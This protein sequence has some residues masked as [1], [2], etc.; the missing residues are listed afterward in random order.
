MT[1]KP[2]LADAGLP[3][4]QLDLIEQFEADYNAVDHFLRKAPGS[5]KLASF[6]H[7]VN[8]YS[9]THA[10]WRDADLLRMIAEL[11][12]VIVHGK[13]APYAYVAVPTPTVV[14]NLRG[15]RDRLINPARVIPKFRGE[16]ETVS[17]DDTLARVL[18]IIKHREYSQFPVYEGKRFQG[19]LTENGITRWLAN[20]VATQF[21]LVELDDVPVKQVLQNEEERR[22]YQFVARDM[23]VD[24][25]S[26]LFK[27]HELLEAVLITA[28]GKESERLLGI[29]TRWDM[30]RL[31]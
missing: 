18:K 25:A 26:G 20:H 10:G 24:D 22:N 30:I 29:A 6:R 4:E 23:R 2:I 8:E 15:C 7:L 27:S 11:R 3:K 17:I 13:T 21:S 19:L 1:S 31:T 16:V 14:R 5:D 9:H 12:N 28:S